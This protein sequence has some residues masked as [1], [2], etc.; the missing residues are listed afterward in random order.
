MACRQPPVGRLDR[1]APVRLRCGGT[2]ATQATRHSIRCKAARHP[3]LVR[4]R[5]KAGDS[6]QSA[7]GATALRP[8]EVDAE[9]FAR[10]VAWSLD[11][12]S[13][14]AYWGQLASPAAGRTP[15]ESGSSSPRFC[16]SLYTNVNSAC[17]VP[18]RFMRNPQT[19]P[20]HVP[21]C[22]CSPRRVCWAPFPEKKDL[23]YARKPFQRSTR[24]AARPPPPSGPTTPRSLSMRLDT[25]SCSA[26]RMA[27]PA[28]GW[29][30]PHCT[31]AQ[32]TTPRLLSAQ[33]P[34]PCTPSWSG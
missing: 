32:K 31:Q 8:E 20:L 18:K 19:R 21:L 12:L 2:A 4:P 34:S 22:M 33:C 29:P 5:G 25:P 23:L 26:S 6:E 9:R 24:P 16:F 1:A 3:D 15:L 13:L 11:T 30:R 17:A 10:C 27:S 28:C 7:S 14:R